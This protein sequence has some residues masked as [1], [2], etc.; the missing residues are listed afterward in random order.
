MNYFINSQLFF[1]PFEL[2]VYKI[3]FI[4]DH[5]YAHAHL[6]NMWRLPSYEDMNRND[7]YLI[8]NITPALKPDK[9]LKFL[10]NNII[11]DFIFVS[12]I[13][14]FMKITDVSTPVS[15]YMYYPKQ[16][17]SDILE[18]AS[19]SHRTKPKV[20]RYLWERIQYLL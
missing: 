9:I 2:I 17:F 18:K 5:L 10:P 7:R 4:N 1:N 8:I 12:M 15:K 16:M 14:R 19:L 6:L 13:H 3:K 11:M 20:S